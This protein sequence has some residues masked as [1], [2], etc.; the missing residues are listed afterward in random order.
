MGAGVALAFKNRYPEMFKDYVHACKNKEIAPG[1][2]HVWVESDL[3]STCTIINFPTKIHWRNPS[4]YEYI[5]K[6]LTW[7][8]D[9]LIDC[10]DTIVTLPALGCGHGGLDWNIVKEMII[11][12]LGN[13]DAKIL[14]F[15]PTSSVNINKN[16]EWVGQLVKH[17][18]VTIQPNDELYPKEITGR[19]S[20]SLY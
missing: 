20:R 17:N 7:L 13:L 12:L 19:S 16:N 9:Y 5:E 10:K 8:R 3:L 4:K 14:V 11:N 1:K 6:G 15:N 2:P 18:V